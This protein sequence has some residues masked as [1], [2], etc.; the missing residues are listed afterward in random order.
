MSILKSAVKGP[1]LLAMLAILLAVNSRGA[2][3]DPTTELGAAGPG[4]WAVLDQ[5]NFSL[6][7]PSGFIHGNVGEA[8]GNFTDGGSAGVTGTIFLG[9]TATGSG[10]AGDHLVSGSTLPASALTLANAAA[11]FYNGVA[12]DFTTAPSP[13]TVTPGVYKITGD[14]SPNGG[15]YNLTAG[16]V[17]VFDVSGNFKPSTGASALLINDATPGDVIFNIGG[18]LQSSGGSSTYPRIDGIVLAQGSISLTPGFI[19]GEI[20]SDTSINIASKGAVQGV[21]DGGCTMMLLGVGA[22]MLFVA[23]RKLTCL[24]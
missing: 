23:R 8:T 20:I 4:N 14:W 7:D 1:G 15:T 21:P 12:A 24:A 5:G 16:Q 22:G 19:D 10:V 2:T 6:S 18:N 17:Y 13:G 11:T 9:S 3:V